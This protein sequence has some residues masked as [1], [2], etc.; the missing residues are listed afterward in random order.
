MKRLLLLLSAFPFLFAACEQEENPFWVEAPSVLSLTPAS[1]SAGAEGGPYEVVLSAPYR[2][3]VEIPS[4]ALGWISFKASAFQD[5]SMTITLQVE[6]NLSYLPREADITVSS[7]GVQS[8]TLKLTQEALELPPDPAPENWEDA[9]TAVKNM[10]AGWNLGNTL[11]ANSGNVDHMWIEA[12][13]NRKPADYETAWGQPV[14]TR[15]LIHMFREAGFNA[16]R[17]PVTWYPHMGTPLA[18][19]SYQDGNGDWHC[20]WDTSTWTGYDVDPA[21]MARVKEVVG[22]VLDEG[23]YC[24]LNVHHDTGDASTAWLRAGEEAFDEVKDRYRSLWEQIATAFADCGQ[25]LLFESYNEMLDP[26]ASWCFASYN[27][28]SR[29][30][31]EVARSAYSA[32]N[33]Y[34]ELFTRTVRAT[35]GKNQY[36]NL[37]VNTY[38]ACSGD[39]TW[40]SHLKEPLSQMQIPEEPGHIAVEVHSYWDAEKFNAQKA[41]I[42]QLFVN[43]DE[44]LVRRLGVPVIIGE[45]GGGTG[46]D[47]NNNV[48]FASYFT[49]KAR[50]AGIATFWWM[51]LSDGED[52]SVPAWTMPRT[53]DAILNSY[54]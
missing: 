19:N 28:P 54:R 35:G 45:W 12:F 2:P 20:I 15:E 37:I 42:D 34:A 52:R 53:K 4:S 16:I 33:S 31:A 51:G 27:S 44:Q 11:D 14:A 6:P 38:G 5:Y 48:R 21:W 46:E 23:M 10:G 30:D 29:Y 40:N 17:V 25:R 8:L 47:T 50:E 41:D 39:G 49:Q 36:R 22:Y 1:V 32:I 26:L 3:R 18:V 24:I 13:T 43:L 7:V 9:A